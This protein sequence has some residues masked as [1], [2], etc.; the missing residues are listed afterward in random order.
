MHFSVVCSED[1]PRMAQPATALT[2]DFGAGLAPLYQQVCSDWPLGSIPAD[3][4]TLPKVT[5]ATL[6]L[7]GGLDPVTPPHHGERV[8]SSLGPLARHEV[9]PKA[10][11]GLLSLGCIRDVVFRFIDAPTD[12]EALQV[13]ADC[14]RDIPRP[15][16]FVPLGGALSP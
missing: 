7:S 10:G 13:K 11:H 2:Q 9:V 4:Y 3:F 5:T 1:V 14:A 6:L 16:A 8:A 12:A 15:P